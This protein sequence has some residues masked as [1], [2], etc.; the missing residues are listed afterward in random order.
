MSIY[1]FS[2]TASSN[3]SADSAINFTEGQLPSTLNDS[4]R[5]LMARIAE[6][7]QDTVKSAITAGTEPNYTLSSTASPSAL[8]DGWRGVVRFHASNT[9]SAPTLALDGFSAKTLTKVDGSAIASGELSA[10]ALYDVMYDIT[11]D[12][13]IV[14]GLTPLNI[15]DAATS[16]M[17]SL[18]D[19]KILVGDGTA[20]EKVYVGV[21]SPSGD[22]YLDLGSSGTDITTGAGVRMFT[23]THSTNAND[24]RVYSAGTVRL[25]FDYS[26]DTWD[27]TAATVTMS[28]DLTITGNMSCDGIADTA[29]STRLTVDDTRVSTTRKLFI[30]DDGASDII[31]L[32]QA[33]S[34]SFATH[35]VRIT[36][37]RSASTAYSLIR[38]YTS[39]TGDLEFHVR[40]DGQ[41]YADGS[42]NGGGADYADYFQWEDGNLQNEDRRGMVVS[43]INDKIKIAS[44]GDDVLGVISANPS[45]A[46]GGAWNHWEG[47]YLRDDFGDYIMEEY[48]VATW[49]VEYKKNG[50]LQTK[51]MEFEVDR[52]P[53]SVDLPRN[54]VISVQQ[55]RKL[56][57]DYSP[58]KEYIPR[59]NRPEWTAVGLLGR[60]PVRN[61]QYVPSSWTK[62][63]VIS[64]NVTEYLVR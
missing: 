16:S 59:E 35:A 25:K 24:F 39:G 10:S 29:T 40:G 58:D 45:I 8:S 55:R 36:V 22:G 49:T 26:A 63:K 1:D 23:S 54:A 15:S 6:F 20:S 4:A 32:F 17:M 18:A 3:G 13:F 34:T 64:D 53:N 27:F 48:R 12:R 2:T 41:V 52:L 14:R 37:A 43:L 60:L 62:L 47:K 56:N 42:F 30:Q 7:I 33:N 38:A 11:N 28:G 51:I 31:G 50:K 44:P 19:G 61:D 5:A 21:D 46:G 57:P 9:S